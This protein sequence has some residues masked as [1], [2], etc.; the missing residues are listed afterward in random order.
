M[1]HFLRKVFKWRRLVLTGYGAS[2]P[3]AIECAG[4]MLVTAGINGKT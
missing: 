3:G 1:T 2:R 4:A